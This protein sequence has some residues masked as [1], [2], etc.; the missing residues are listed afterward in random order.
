MAAAGE[1]VY[2]GATA[3]LSAASAVSA[4]GPMQADRKKGKQE[5]PPISRAEQMNLEHAQKVKAKRKRYAPSGPRNIDLIG[6]KQTY[7]QY[8]YNKMWDSM[9]GGQKFGAVM[10]G[11]A[12]K[13]VGRP[14]MWY[15]ENY[16]ETKD[17]HK[18]KSTPEALAT[19]DRA[20]ADFR[21]AQLDEEED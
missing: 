8:R 5:E 16:G 17:I 15:R 6:D 20:D 9:T 21:M 12:K 2:G 1:S 7:S 4:A 13:T 11:L 14:Y 18:E 3:P 10:K 19:M